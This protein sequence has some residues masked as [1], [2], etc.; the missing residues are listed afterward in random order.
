MT[1]AL[2]HRPEAGTVFRVASANLEDGGYD[3]NHPGRLR[4]T[5]RLLA[6]LH[7]H[8][9]VLQ[10]CVGSG[11]GAVH[12]QAPIRLCEQVLGLTAAGL[13]I[14]RTPHHQLLLYDP[15][16]FAFAPEDWFDAHSAEVWHGTA[17]AILTHRATG[18]SIAASS[19]HLTPN[20]TS[21][22]EQEAQFIG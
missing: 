15:S 3:G 8:L 11:P 18:R 22:A 14:G 16:R 5:L 12:G 1:A 4:R 10:E 7:P 17:T 19:M 20:G 9:V 21:T 2:Q 13:I 6:G